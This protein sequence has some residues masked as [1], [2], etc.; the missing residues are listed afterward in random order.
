MFVESESS[1]CGHVVHGGLHKKNYR[2]GTHREREKER[3]REERERRERR[4]RR[5]ERERE[6]GRENDFFVVVIMRCVTEFKQT[7]CFV[8]QILITPKV[9]SL[10]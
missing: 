9:L 10:S 2:L 4:E 8:H 1:K 6:K 7:K 3:E 5:R